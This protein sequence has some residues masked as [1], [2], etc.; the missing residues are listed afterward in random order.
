[1]IVGLS[2]GQ[3]IF[4]H[5]FSAEPNPD[6]VLEVAPPCSGDLVRLS[7]VYSGPDGV[8]VRVF[9]R[10]NGSQL[11]ASFAG[12][13]SGDLLTVDARGGNFG[14]LLS[15]TW[16]DI[17]DPSSP[18]SSNNGCAVAVP[19][20]CGSYA[21]NRTFG[22]LTVTAFTDQNG[23]TVQLGLVGNGN[24]QVS[25][26]P[27]QTGNTNGPGGN[28]GTFTNR[29]VSANVG[30][31]NGSPRRNNGQGQAKS[32]A[33]L[34][35]NGLSHNITTDEL[36]VNPGDGIVITSDLVEVQASDLD[37]QGVYTDNNNIH[38]NTGDGI[39]INAD[40][41]EVRASDL[42][43]AG[44]SEN[45]NDLNVNVDGT[46][47]EIDPNNDL[48]IASGAAGNGLYGG[49]NDVLHV[50]DGQ[51]IGVN[52][53]QI[54]VNVDNSTI[55]IEPL[56]DALRVAQG[57]ISN[58]EL[59]TDAV[60]TGNIIDGTVAPRDMLSGGNNKVLT[61]DGSG[62]VQWSDFSTVQSAATDGDGLVVDPFNNETDVNTGDG[63]TINA[64]AVE[65]VAS[66]LEGD[67]LS[68]SSNNL[69]VNTGDGLTINSD[70]V[71]VVASDLD[72]N[73]L[74]TSGNDLAV[75]PG[76]GI[77]VFADQVSVNPFDLDGD[78]LSGDPSTFDLDINTDNSTIEVDGSDNLRVIPEGITA[79]EIGTGAVTSDEILDGTIQGHDLHQNG[80]SNGQVLIWNGTSWVPGTNN[81]ND[82]DPT[83]E[84]NT[85]ATLTGNTLNITDA[86]GTQTVDLSVLNNPGSDDQNL[87]GA[88]LDTSDNLTITIENGSSTT[89]DLSSLE[90]SADIAQVASDLSAHTTADQ[91]LSSSNELQTLSQSGNNV[92]LSN[93]GGT[94]SVADNDNDP[95][96]EYNTGASLTGNTLNITDGGGTQTVDLSVLNNPGSDDQ[97]LTGATLDASDNLTIT[98]ENGS[99]TTVDLSSLEESADIAQVAS[100]LSAHTTADQDLSSSN[101]LQTL[102]QS[103]NSVTL[104][105]GGGTINV[106]D[107]DNDSSNEL[108]TLSKSG[109]TVTLSNGG[110][111]F[112]DEVNDADASATN[113]LQTLTLSGNQLSISSGNTINLPPDNDSDPTNEI[114]DLS[115]STS[116]TNRTINITGG[117]STTF[118]IADNDNS[119]SNELQTLSKSGSTVTLSNGGGSFTDEVN[120]ADASSTNEL[121]TLSTSGGNLVLS[122]GGG[123]VPIS[124]LGDTDWTVSGSNQY[125]A[126]SGNVGI[127]TTAPA[128][129]LH[130][131]GGGIR[132]PAGTV[133]QLY[134][135]GAP[136]GTPTTDA[137]RLRSSNNEF[138]S[139]LDALVIEKTDGNNADP[140]G[141]IHFVMTG[142]DGIQ[143]SAMAIRGTGNVGIG[144]TAPTAELDVDGRARVRNLPNN[145]TQS[146]VVVT[147]NNG[148]LS[149][150][151]IS[152]IQDNDSDPGNELQTISKSGSTVTLSN[153]GGSFTDAVNDAD[154][155]PTNE[156]QSLSIS[157]STISLNNGGG[158]VTV[159]SS[160]DNL[161]N[162][163]ATTNLNMVDRNINNVG[164][165][166]ITDPGPT[167]GMR[168]GSTAA[169][170]MIDVSPR[171]RTNTDGDL[172]LYGTANNIIA[173]RPLYERIGSTDY[174]VWN[175]GN[176][177]VGSGL[178]ADRLDGQQG[179]FYLDNTDSQNLTSSSSGTNR[180]I[181]ISG[182]SGTTFSIADNDNST[183]NELQNLSI[184]GSTISLSNGGG[185]VTVP[186]TAD[187]LGNH[188]ATQ[189]L[190]MNDLAL[191]DANTVQ[192]NTLLDPEDSEITISDNLR[193][194]GNMSHT[195]NL[196]SLGTNYSSTWMQFDQDQF[197]NA[198]YLGS[199]GLSV[200][201][202]GESASS[203]RGN[204][205]PADETLHLTSD[206]GMQFYTNMQSGW[207]ARVNAMSINNSGVLTVPNLGGSGNRMVIA[208]GSGTLSTQSIPVNTD[209]QTLSASTSGTTRNIS[210][211][212]GNTVGINVAD[213]DNSSSNELQNLSISGSTISLSGGG[214]SVTVPA[215]ADNLG[216]H[217]ATTR[218][219]MNG[220]DLDFER[221][222]ISAIRSV[223]EISFD[224]TTGTYD[225]PLNHG[226]R[227]A[228][229][230]GTLTDD[231]SINSFD[232][233]TMRIDANNN[234][235]TAFFRVEHHSTGNGSDLFWVRSPD[236]YAYHANRLGIGTTSPAADLHA[237]R[238]DN[239]IAR[240]YATGSGQGSGMFYAGQS[241]S[242]GGGF[243]Y[244]GDGT[245]ALVGGS[246]RITFFRRN[247]NT[248]TEVMSYGYS[249]STLR[250]N[251]LAGSGN[252]MV[253]ANAN[254][255]LITQTIPAGG[256]DNLG[257]HT[258]TTNLNM[259]NREVDAVTYLD[260]TAGNGYGVRFWSSNS[261]AINMGNA[262][263]YKLGPVTDYSIKTNMSNT[264]TRGWTWGVDGATP[265]M[266]LNTQGHLQIQGAM[267]FDCP[268]CGSQ[269]STFGGTSGW[270]DLV[271]QGRV[272]STSSNLHLSP[273]NGYNVIIDDAY[274]AAGGSGGGSA[275]LI[276]EGTVQGNN[277]F[278]VDGNVVIDNGGGWH[279][280]YG[281]TGWYN[282]TYGGGWYM[283]DNTWV[284]AYNSKSVWTPA[285]MQADTRMQ[286]ATLQ[287]GNWSI[288]N[289]A[290][291]DGQFF[292]NT[293]GYSQHRFDDW[294][295]IMDNGG[296][297][298][299]W[300]NV[301]AGDMW[302]ANYYNFSDRN[303]KENIRPIESAVDIVKNLNGVRYDLKREEFPVNDEDVEDVL[304]GR[305]GFIA[306][307]VQEVMPEIIRQPA[308]GEDGKEAPLGVNYSAIIPVL[309][310]AMKEQQTRIEELEAQVGQDHSGSKVQ[311]ADQPVYDLEMLQEMQKTIAM[312][313]QLI[314]GM[315]SEMD[316]LR[317]LLK[318]AQADDD[319]RFEEMLT[320]IYLS[321]QAIIELGG[322]CD[323][324][325]DENSLETGDNETLLFQ[326][327]PN[328]FNKVTTI[329]YKL[330]NP[331]HTE[332][333]IYDESSLPVET[334]VDA[335]QDAGVYNVEWDGTQFTSGVYIYM[336]KQNNVVLAKKMV[337]IK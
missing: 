137:F 253:V 155:S 331:G 237:F 174:R 219:D 59:A 150:R 65:V 326:N 264:T 151:D 306:Q 314:D 320:R 186:A 113:E 275:G 140:D 52:A 263:E 11:L 78:G 29:T 129:K 85:G 239:D 223:G 190:D 202:S 20:G 2:A 313:Q 235:A 66:D 127:G 335:D 148:N 14:N 301:P 106:A 138:G 166:L 337:L 192:T 31:S 21:S 330:A 87:T 141:G 290:A 245:P 286:S 218:L 199:G 120:D 241:N 272:M 103:G 71:E 221:G 277:G 185:S 280:S 42:D 107:N 289:P 242:Y 285:T 126:V 6:P 260:V 303:L 15:T 128:A 299:F 216:N 54:Q 311:D 315:T 172:N 329:T 154:A 323:D 165:V 177:G 333:V 291:S 105:N 53:N 189:N 207:T 102:S 167:E 279:R 47:I 79:N 110:G 81:D 270:G 196:V 327:H 322:C 288:S 169:G 304:I 184:S 300:W 225:S 175:A 261:Y 19:S 74:T 121:Q 33:D 86:G 168:W 134:S 252:R 308:A 44:L 254:G 268:G 269:S 302:A 248:D 153:G 101:E 183:S 332:L 119:T 37:G 91:D 5:T 97:N 32:A 226:I 243:V 231:L 34:D 324:K 115:S 17:Q 48:R 146:R 206:Q 27:T 117:T 132:V 233:V 205:S 130:V 156:I 116:G 112:T 210:I 25:A 70:N 325:A 40:Q 193:T 236:G 276:V 164:S 247:N 208:N 310:E 123:S 152:T 250:I 51:G 194:N 36:D 69:N 238:P 180:T 170:W 173:W 39:R 49:S 104:S 35:G 26:P 224:W 267:K 43:G 122:N 4:A 295:M 109:S 83:N 305:Y 191:L 98:I 84:Y 262:A 3:S 12:V 143:E 68:V 230:N 228:D 7:L 158:S 142:N 136:S 188:N 147:D 316:R 251:S 144:T 1:M 9:R 271:I 163:T 96:N 312:Q 157:G 234:D 317:E 198:L 58:N 145:N 38:V 125:S 77:G 63:L 55:D 82:S 171:N 211:S 80:A 294:H 293:S 249:N 282:G 296:T 41:V 232:D 149:Y 118:N 203:L 287:Y 256:N 124:T 131:D 72:G 161:G 244:D 73:G 318:K 197:G 64:D 284:R 334:I 93:G 24:R 22:L 298:R 222:D 8:T 246:D 57:G 200:Y 265:V 229:E 328:P 178:D 50:G 30:I 16:F 46:T 56:N 255:D 212:G 162:H 135:D 159:P 240:V 176:D 45:G 114:Q 28:L 215:G 321:E 278:S 160:A 214:G 213:N 257:N 111:S 23:Q 90:E 259:G 108:Q 88:T 336:L 227:S 204:V 292:R 274:R 76:H 92:T 266:A 217:S 67:G 297:Y 179:S 220:N 62:N 89:V 283:T 18:C 61:T 95:T 10:P 100:D 319:E 133:T 94:I 13:N 307:D 60:G 201:G 181:N 75:N 182:G 99:S 187:N 309:V 258:A 209:N 195:G 139:S 273:P 281:Q